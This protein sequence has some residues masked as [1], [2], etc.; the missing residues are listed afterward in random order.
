[1]SKQLRLGFPENAL[2]FEDICISSSNE[3]ALIVIRDIARWPAPAICLLGAPRSGLTT[4]AQAWAIEQ[5]ADL[6][7]TDEFDQMGHECIEKLASSHSAIDN[8]DRVKNKDNLLSLIN[9]S[10]TH[11]TCILLT[12][13]ISPTNW[14]MGGSADLR[15][16]LESMPIVELEEPDHGLLAERLIAAC[17]QRFLKLPENAAEFLAKR[18]ERSFEAIEDLADR[19]DAAVSEPGTKLTVKT[20]RD[21]LKEGAGTRPLFDDDTD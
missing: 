19:L 7:S 2:G 17:R 16:R 5:K 4:G 1:M 8:A 10:E 21:V 12:S 13:R 9:L 20:A 15:S 11:R 6:V 3:A 14:P 18:M